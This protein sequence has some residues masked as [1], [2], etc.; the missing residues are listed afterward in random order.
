MKSDMLSNETVAASP[1]ASLCSGDVLS[2]PRSPG[3]VA[4]A[5]VV[6]LTFYKRW[7]S[8][9]LPPAC[10]FLPTCSEYAMEAVHHHGAFRGVWMSIRR[11]GRCH[12]RHPGGLDPVPPAPEEGAS[13]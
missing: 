7:I 3:L 8:V 2:V 5:L 4:R 12:P 13:R 10:R 1:R 11:V 6:V 9:M